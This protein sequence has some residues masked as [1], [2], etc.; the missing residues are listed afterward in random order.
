MISDI[1]DLSKIEA[2]RIE[3]YVEEFDV[4][5]L[6]T[7]LASTVQSLV[8]QGANTLVVRCS[9]ELGFALGVSDYLT[10]PIDRNRLVTVL[11]RICGVDNRRVLVVED[12][13]STRKLLD[14]TLSRS[15]WI[16]S[17][18]ENGIAALSR[19]KEN[20]PDVILLDLM[21]PEMD[22]FEFLHQLRQDDA[23]RNIPIIVLTAKD[24]TVHERNVLTGQV[25]RIL[26]K[27]PL[28]RDAL[29]TEVRNLINVYAGKPAALEET[30]KT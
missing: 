23:Y 27:G 9:E 10:K 16:V 26:Q 6:I 24:L 28:S 18:A 8:E 14:R 7:E 17:E 25:N 5:E 21:M 12:D 29:M 4:P 11:N 1:L 22:G 2:G 20:T 3:L 13:E 19:V 15:G 30:P